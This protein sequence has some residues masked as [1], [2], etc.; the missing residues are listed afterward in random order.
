MDRIVVQRRFPKANIPQLKRVAAY[1]RVSSGKDAMLHSLSAQVSYY[2]DLI[3]NHSGW[4][5]AGVYAD[6]ALTGTKDNRENFQRLLADCR[7]GKVDMVITKSISR[8]ARN[9]VTLL[10]TV[11]ELKT[12]GV[13]VFFEE[14]NIHSLSADGELMLTILAS[15]AQ[16][17]SLS[18]SE[19]QKWRIRHNYENGLAWNGTI[20]GYRYDHGTY[21]IEPQ[22][23]ETVRLIFDSYLQGMGLMAIIKMLNTEGRVSRYGNTWGQTNLMRVLRNYTYTGNLLLQQTFSENHLTKRRRQN[24]GEL[25]MYHI[26]DAHEAI[27]PLEQFNAVQEE[28]RRRAEKHYTPHRNK[29]KYPFS[30]LLVCTGCG[31]HYRRK[32]TASGPVW[33]CPTFNS[34]GK[35]FCQSK[36]IPEDILIAATKE[37]IG[38]LD[39]LHSKITAVRVENDNTLVFCLTGG[40]QIVKRWQDRSRRQS[41]TPEMKNAA[42]QKEME[43]RSHHDKC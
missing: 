11:R 30:G 43:R 31:K 5:Y 8:F 28:I 27:I 1:A 9:T 42:R 19:N 25:P 29:G 34:K 14:Q 4:Q 13:D 39:S 36:Q 26:K 37:V 40:E 10:E 20:L 41:W 18:A 15:Y 21:I 2:S 22:E 3:Q 33:I 16:E 38:S 23:A 6:E 24:N 32:N 7:S 12:M 35:A 17:E